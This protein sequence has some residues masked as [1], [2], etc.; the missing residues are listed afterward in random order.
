MIGTLDEEL[1]SQIL[2]ECG[3]QGEITEKQFVDILL[4]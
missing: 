1:W 4:N 2:D 3:A